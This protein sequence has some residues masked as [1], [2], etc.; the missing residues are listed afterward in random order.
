M[1]PDHK[2]SDPVT[3]VDEHGDYLYRYALLR[4]RDS[5]VAED[6]IQ[7]TLLAAIGAYRRHAGRSSERTWLVGILKHKIVDHFR[8]IT[9]RREFHFFNDDERNELDLFERDGEWVG[10]WRADQAPVSWPLDAVKLMEAKE[11][12]E[13]FDR[14]LSSLS[15]RAVIAFTL[16]EI[17]GLSS[18]EICEVLG[19]TPDNLWVILHRARAKLR[20]ALE[21]EWFRGR[22]HDFPKSARLVNQ[23]QRT[24]ASVRPGLSYR[25]VAA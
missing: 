8:Q 22:D 13:T 25:A 4:T 17:D 6:L 5:S 2:L 21:V 7:E 12:W 18:K 11:F 23:Q 10:H 1:S 24:T 20:Q 14:C 9:R 16:R 19:V 15:H 3:W